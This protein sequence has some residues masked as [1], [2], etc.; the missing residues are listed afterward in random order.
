MKNLVDTINTALADRDA[1]QRIVTEAWLLL[2]D[3][4]G[5]ATSDIP[6]KILGRIDTFIEQYEMP[7]L[8]KPSKASEITN[9]LGQLPNAD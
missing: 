6:P 8:R 4:Q 3:I 2:Y 5:N 1:L 7:A 9:Q